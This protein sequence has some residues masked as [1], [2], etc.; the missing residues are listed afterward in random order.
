ML[1]AEN[2]PRHIADI[3]NSWFKQPVNKTQKL[4]EWEGLFFFFLISGVS[5]Y[6]NNFFKREVVNLVLLYK[7]V[8]AE[9]PH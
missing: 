6:D 9:K 3:R 1:F 4:K 5:F 7:I 2:N 8:G